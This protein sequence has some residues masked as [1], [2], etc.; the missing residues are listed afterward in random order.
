MKRITSGKP[1]F[2]IDENLSSHLSLFLRSL[3][4]DAISVQEAS[5]SGHSDS[6]IITWASGR[7]RT[8]I[9]QDLGFGLVYVQTETSPSIVLL[10]SK[11]GTTEAYALP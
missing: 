5:L 11:T 1:K 10:R 2:L 7:K 8:V 9:T 4:Y 6:A 3:G